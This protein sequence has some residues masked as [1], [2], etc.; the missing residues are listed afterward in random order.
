MVKTSA[1][2]AKLLITRTLSFSKFKHLPVKS[3][4]LFLCFYIEKKKKFIV[5]LLS[6][7]EQNLLSFLVTDLKIWYIIN[8]CMVTKK[9]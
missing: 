7:F 4:L 1:I 9:S 5:V 3:K 8:K 6:F 2:F